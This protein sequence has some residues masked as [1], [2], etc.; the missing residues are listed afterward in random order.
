MQ[1]LIGNNSF[2]FPAEI[3]KIL[4]ETKNAVEIAVQFCRAFFEITVN[5]VKV[6]CLI[7]FLEDTEI[8]VKNGVINQRFPIRYLSLYVVEECRCFSIVQGDYMCS[9]FLENIFYNYG[10]MRIIE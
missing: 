1:Y 5:F 7:E 6:S 2:K 3:F 8:L 4:F 10:F 9:D